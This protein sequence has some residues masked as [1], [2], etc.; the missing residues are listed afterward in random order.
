MVSPNIY[1]AVDPLG[2][3]CHF[4]LSYTEVAP[5]PVLS[6]LAMRQQGCVWN[7]IEIRH[8]VTEVQRTFPLPNVGKKDANG[9]YSATVSQG[10]INAAGFTNMRDLSSWTVS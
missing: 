1:E 5:Y 8:S 2:F 3:V 7:Q 10:A 6:V 9:F 4:E